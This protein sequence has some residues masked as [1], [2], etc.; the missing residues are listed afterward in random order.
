MTRQ[1]RPKQPIL[2]L[3]PGMYDAFN[4]R[5]QAL[6]LGYKVHSYTWSSSTGARAVVE[7]K[8]GRKFTVI[9]EDLCPQPEVVVV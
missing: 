4:L 7:D 5:L 8:Q 3:G 2:S 9:E 1:N 6:A